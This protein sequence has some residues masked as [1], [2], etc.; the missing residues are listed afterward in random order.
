[1]NEWTKGWIDEWVWMNVQLKEWTNKKLMN[2]WIEDI[3]IN[4]WRDK[5][6]EWMNGRWWKDFM[7]V[8]YFGIYRL[9]LGIDNS[10]NCNCVRG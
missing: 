10:H 3:E 7:M 8:H 5:M 2:G 9:P 1:M 4:D 6:S